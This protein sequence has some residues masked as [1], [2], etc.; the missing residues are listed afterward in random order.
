MSVSE[1]QS[2]LRHVSGVMSDIER[3]ILQFTDNTQDTM[4][5][6]IRALDGTSTGADAEIKGALQDAENTIHNAMRAINEAISATD[7][8][9][10]RL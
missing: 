1:L 3:T 10:R 9:S 7:D 5:S 2:A 6:T 4:R 8:F